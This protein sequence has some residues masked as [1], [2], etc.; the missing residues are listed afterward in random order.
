MISKN[1]HFSASVAFIVTFCGSTILTNE[2]IVIAFRG[3]L[4]LHR[5]PGTDMVIGKEVYQVPN[6]KQIRQ[7]SRPP[8]VLSASCLVRQVSRPLV[9]SFAS[10]L[11]YQLTKNLSLSSENTKEI[12]TALKIVLSSSQ[13]Y[14]C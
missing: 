4:L 9:V 6:D 5:C 1:V 3:D 12:F 8:V 14:I 7:L 10:C 13:I 11:V 2:Q